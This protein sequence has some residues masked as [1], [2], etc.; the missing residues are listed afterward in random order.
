MITEGPVLPLVEVEVMAPSGGFILGRSRLDVDNL[1]DGDEEL[2]WQPY[3]AEA[4]T[5]GCERGGKRAGVVNTMQVGTLVITLKNAGTPDTDP[6]MTPNT[7][8][9]FKAKGD[10]RPFFSGAISDI[11]MEHRIDKRTGQIDTFV[12]IA[13]VDAVQQHANTNRYGAIAPAGFERWEER[14]ARLAQSSQAPV[15]VPPVDEPIVRYAL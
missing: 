11:D 3:L 5:V 6:G 9:R 10:G 4:T 15:N 8:I 7:P 14:I 1:G 13:A 2:Q 12:T